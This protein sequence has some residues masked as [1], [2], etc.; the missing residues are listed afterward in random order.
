MRDVALWLLTVEAIGLAFLPLTVWLFRWLPD[1]GYAFGKFLGLLLVTYVTWLAGN[2]LPIVRSPLLPGALVLVAAALGWWAAR[3]RTV[4][5]LREI[6]RTVAVEEALFLTA[7]IGYT[8]LRAHVFGPDI[9]HSEQPMDM[10]FLNSSVRS[11]SYPPYDP[12][13]S[14]HP[15]NYYYFGYLMCATLIKLSGVGIGVGYNLALSFVV[16]SVVVGAYS[17][18]YVLTRRYTWSVLAPVFLVLLGNWHALLWQVPHSGCTGASPNGSPSWW[19][20]SWMWES[21]RV[22]HDHFTLADWSCARVGLPVNSDTINEYPLFSFVLGDLHAHVIGLPATL[23]ALALACNVLKAPGIPRVRRDAQ[24]LAQLAVMAICIGVLFTI[25]SWDFPTYLLVVAACIAINAYIMDA[26]R[27]WWE[28]PLQTIL[29]LGAASLVLFAP[30]YLHFRSLAHGIGWVSTPSNLYE[31]AQVFGFCLLA[32]VFLIG[33]LQLLLLPAEKETVAEQAWE[34]SGGAAGAISAGSER[35]SASYLEIAGLALAVVAIVALGGALHRSVLLLL[36]ALGVWSLFV[37]FRV[38]NT[39][40]PNRS[41]AMSLALVGVAILILA[42]T[43][44]AYLRD[45]FDNGSGYRMNTV[46]KFYYQGWTLLA[47]A[48]AYGAYRGWSILRNYVAG[49][50]AWTAVAVLAVGAG[51]AALYTWHVPDY[52]AGASLSSAGSLDGSA[53]LRASH[54]ADYAGILWLRDH[55][56]DDSVVLEAPGKEYDAGTS[57]VA[58]F[59]GLP[60]VL[61]WGGHEDQWH[62]NDPEVGVR[63]IDVGTIFSTTDPRAAQRLMR[64]YHVRYV[65]VGDFERQ[66]YAANPAELTKFARFMRIVFRSGATMIYAW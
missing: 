22:V 51:G 56:N 21:T 31:F 49:G 38:L 15:I 33:S 65:F 30:F 45:V 12:W 18:G 41:D 43:E 34:P 7:L 14:G 27:N 66:T 23:L 6:R 20:W 58:T 5:A 28:E 11:A 4:R 8:L 46:F 35:G 16:A 2:V 61:G 53:W 37:L 59:S 50:F 17:L 44:V 57:R 24:D 47:I 3:D 42:F 1:R 48:G 9:S 60:T 40:E 54:P 39:E 55:V 26:T 13:M 52:A 63:A 36:F 19:F 62:P 64:K 10:A 25:N 32:V 29:A